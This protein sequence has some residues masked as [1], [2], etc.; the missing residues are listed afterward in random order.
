MSRVILM[1]LLAVVSSSAVQAEIYKHIDSNGRVT[2]SSG[3]ETGFNK[4]EPGQLPTTLSPASVDGARCPTV[5]ASSPHSSGIDDYRAKALDYFEADIYGNARTGRISWVQLVDSFYARCIEI[6][7]GQFYITHNRE[8][9]A[10]QRM[11]A[12]QMD[13]KEITESQWAYLIE[14]KLGEMR[15]RT[16]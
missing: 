2:Y 4:L 5:L 1:L 7:K 8:L 13:A 12:E 16:R 10:Y 3:S 11:L 15:A 9:Q 14:K 6:F